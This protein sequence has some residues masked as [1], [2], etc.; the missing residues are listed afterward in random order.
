MDTVG[1]TFGE[2]RGEFDLTL[3]ILRLAARGEGRTRIMYGANISHTML[4]RYLDGLTQRGFIERRGENYGLTSK[5][6]ALK[7]DMERVLA[8]FRSNDETEV[9]QAERVRRFG[10]SA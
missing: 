9:L 1:G 10:S 2:R 4:K 8:H 7:R 6:L 5:G 3:E